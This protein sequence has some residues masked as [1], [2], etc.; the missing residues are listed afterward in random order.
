[1]DHTNRRVAALHL[2]LIEEIDAKTKADIHLELGQIAVSEGKFPQATRHFKEALWFD[3]SLHAA[4]TALHALGEWVDAKAH[5]HR[6]G[7]VLRFL[8]G[9]L[10]G[11][12]A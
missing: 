9:Q 10:R 2:Q 12:P 5:S 6:S 8:W 7:G 1:M 4:R 3:P 11:R